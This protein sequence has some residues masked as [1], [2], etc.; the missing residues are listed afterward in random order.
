[1]R[2]RRATRGGAYTLEIETGS[3]GTTVVPMGGVEDLAVRAAGEIRR[4]LADFDLELRNL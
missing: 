3:F 2:I 1:V 4:V